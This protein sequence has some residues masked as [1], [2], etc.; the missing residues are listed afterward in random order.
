MEL[1]GIYLIACA[2]LVGAGVAKA[3]RPAGTARALAELMPMRFAT[4]VAA[5]RFGAVLEALV[6]LVALVVPR[7]APAALVA[8]SFTFFGGVVL[9]ARTRG[10]ALASCGCFGTLDT[11]ATGLHVV[12]DIALAVSAV[13]VAVS[14][15]SGTLGSVLSHQPLHGLPLIGASGVGTWLCVLAMSVLG[16]L[17]A[18]RRLT[19]VTFERAK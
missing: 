12:I 15:T 2:L 8:L 17:Q 7:S 1:I 4:M 9:Y 14:G 3:V 10:G 18:A 19:G 11:P 13:V 16:E 6:G 5:V